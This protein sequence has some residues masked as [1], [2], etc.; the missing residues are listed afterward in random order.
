[1]AKQQ[2]TATGRK[3]ATEVDGHKIAKPRLL[4][5]E[6]DRE[7]TRRNDEAL[8]N[9]QADAGIK[10]VKTESP[11]PQKTGDVKPKDG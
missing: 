3:L 2:P 4:D 9:Y 1:M 5:A 6:H 11:T 8:T 10:E 7:I